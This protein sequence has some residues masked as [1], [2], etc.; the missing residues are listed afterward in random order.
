MTN[1]VQIPHERNDVVGQAAFHILET[2]A[3]PAAEADDPVLEDLE[4]NLQ[5][6]LQ[7]FPE[8]TGKTITVGRMDPDEDDYIGYAQFWNL[9]IQF[10]ADS[11]TSWRTVYHELAHLAIHVQN[12]QGEDVPPTSEPFCSIVG[13]SRMSVE[14]IDGDRISYLGYP[15]VPRE[16]WPEICERALEYREEHGPNSHYINQCCDWLGIDDRESRTAY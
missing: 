2:F 1:T 16:E 4:R 15:S 14:L 6:A 3:G 11:P 8:L 9:M 13:I 12:Q 5:R 10:P 7:D